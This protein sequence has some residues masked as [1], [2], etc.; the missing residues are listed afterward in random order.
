MRSKVGTQVTPTGESSRTSGQLKQ[1]GGSLMFHRIL[2]PVSDSP[3]SERAAETAA[4]LSRLLGCRLVFMHVLTDEEAELEEGREVAQRL[5][6]RLARPARFQPVLRLTTVD[7]QSIA[8]RILEVAREEQADLIVMG[9]HGRQGAERLVLGSL[10]Q[11][12]AGSSEI[13]VQIIPV[14]VREPN[15]FADRWRRALGETLRS[16]R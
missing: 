10:A 7:G 11:A 2:I 1:P 8:E 3:C 15:Q 13:P 14:R 6:E 16:E 5:L 9:T 4:Q 12:V